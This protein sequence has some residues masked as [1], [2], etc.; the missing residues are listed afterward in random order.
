[1]RWCYIYFCYSNIYIVLTV[2][3]GEK[4]WGGVWICNVENCPN[5]LSMHHEKK[6]RL[7]FVIYTGG[8]GGGTKPKPK[9]KTKKQTKKTQTKKPQKHKR[10]L[11][12]CQGAN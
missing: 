5:H 8:G 10:T 3:S 2:T 6:K 12:L 4:E 7:F 9:S 11:L 1:M